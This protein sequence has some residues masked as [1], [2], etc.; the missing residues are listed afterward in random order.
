MGAP[1]VDSGRR[2]AGVVAA[3]LLVAVTLL[4][5]A[6]S[7]GVFL[8]GDD[9]LMFQVTRSIVEDRDVRVTS[10]TWNEVAD[11]PALDTA[12]FTAASIPGVD[13]ARY[14]KY[15]VGQ[16]L[17]AIPAFIAGTH[18]ISRLLPL[19]I[20]VDAWGNEYTGTPIYAVGL[21]NALIGGMTV[22]LLFLLSVALGYPQRTGFVLAGLLVT[23]TVLSHYAASFLSEP[24]SALCLTAVV[25]GIVRAR[26]AES[27]SG[28]L[29]LSGFAA[30]LALA[31]KIALVVAVIAPGLWLLWLLWQRERGEIRA[32]GRMCLAWGAPVALWLG[33][34]G[35]YNWLRFGSLTET[36]YGAEANA[37]T[38]PLLDGL[39]GLLFSPGRGLFWHDPPLLLACV[40][41]VLFGRRHPGL[42]LTILGMLA[43][44]LLLY[45]RYYAWWGGGVWGPR[46][47]VPLLP[48]LLLPAAE[49]IERAW[50]GRRWAVVSVGAVAILGAIVTALPILVPFDRYVAVYMSSPEMLREALWTVSGSPIVVAARDVLDGHVTLDIAAMR[51]GDGRL[52]VASVA[53]GALGLVLLVF[54]GLRVMREETGDG[55]R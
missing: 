32:V 24:L 25:Y 23:G 53:A 27:A 38:T 34:I 45:G 8:Y 30:G 48:L 6:I 12:G 18:W 16:S 2:G 17:V 44:L 52:V 13:G 37:Y 46:F 14:A 7:R 1:G 36:G 55:P 28:W 21:V 3:L 49:V 29:A 50:S 35:A 22:A 40:G 9:T 4:N 47:L 26:N 5:V 20:R 15:G 54:A 39:V 33:V 10:P 43:G 19:D 51:Y 11:N 31:T 41:A 42:A